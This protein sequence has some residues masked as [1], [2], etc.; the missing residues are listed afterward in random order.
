MAMEFFINEILDDEEG[1][2]LLRTDKE[3]AAKGKAIADEYAVSRKKPPMEDDIL[4]L[5]VLAHLADYTRKEQE[6]LGIPH[7]ITVASLRDVNLWIGN[8]RNVHGK[9]GVMEFD[10][11]LYHWRSEIFRIGRLQFR[12]LKA[13]ESTPSGE[14]E[15]EVHIPQGEPLKPEACLDSFERAKEFMAKIYP[16]KKFDYFVCSSWLL[17]PHLANFLPEDGNT[18]RFMRMWTIH[19]LA[20]TQSN[21][22]TSRILRMGMKREELTADTPAVTSMQK[23]LK[24]YLLAGGDFRDGRGYRKA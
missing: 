13:R 24:E 7:E 12:P 4:P 17:S 9:F 2:E 23:A 16:E 11:L 14:Y 22:V 18:V 10:W 3:R 8:Y 1:K 21:A 6:A 19:S 20:E 5:F 15:L